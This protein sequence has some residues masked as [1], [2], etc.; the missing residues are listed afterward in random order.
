MSKVEPQAYA[1]MSVEFFAVL[2]PWACTLA[3]CPAILP[4]S[5]LDKSTFTEPGLDWHMASRFLITI[6]KSEHSS[7]ASRIMV[8]LLS[9]AI[10]SFIRLTESMT[11]KSQYFDPGFCF[12]DS[13][14]RF[15]IAEEIVVSSFDQQSCRKSDKNI[16]VGRLRLSSV[17]EQ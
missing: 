9:P 15:F 4:L 1:E 16:S 5:R 3:I 2:R 10:T 17:P 12:S 11:A 6:E 8:V 7:R 14:Y 13:L